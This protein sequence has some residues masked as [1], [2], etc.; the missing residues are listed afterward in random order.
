[1]QASPL[2]L[3]LDRNRLDP[4]TAEIQAKGLLWAKSSFTDAAIKYANKFITQTTPW[5]SLTPIPDGDGHGISSP[6]FFA[7]SST[8]GFTK[9]FPDHRDIQRSSQ[10]VAKLSYTA[11]SICRS[12]A[13]TQE[14]SPVAFSVP[15]LRQPHRPS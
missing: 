1:M 6:I 11:R 3:Q 2:V 12:F 14:P 13:A 8:F 15:S 10:S 4:F 5:S 7:I 9:L